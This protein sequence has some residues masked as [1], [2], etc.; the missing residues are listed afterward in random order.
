VELYDDQDQRW[1]KGTALVHLA[2]VSLGLGDIKQALQW[3]DTAKPLLNA[4]GD[5]WT[6]AFGLNNYG[7]VARAQGD[8]DQA[9][10]YY[11][12]TDELYKQADSKG[13]QARLLTVLGYIA[14]HKS[15]FDEARRLFLESLE[16]FRK[17]GNNRGIAE[18]LAGLS[19]LAAELGEHR[20]A[21]HLLSAAEA[22]LED[23][24]GVWWPADRV[25]IDLAKER[26]QAALGDQY[27]AIWQEGQEMPLNQAIDAALK[28][29]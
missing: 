2:N 19:G 10:A 29:W 16:E 24:E 18:S 14:Q 9:E 15:E 23:L 8:Y 26:L 5:I 3:L 6:M 22:R 1:L 21:L 27:E 7:E 17:L 11:R 20:W 13:D 12:R 25:E 4:T 28:G